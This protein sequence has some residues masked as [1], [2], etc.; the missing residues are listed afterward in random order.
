MYLALENIRSLYN[1][2]SILRTAEFFGV[3]RVLLVGYSGRKN[4][5]INELHDR[6][7]KTSLG[8]EKDLEI[9]FLDNSRDLIKFSEDRNLSLVGVEIDKKSVNLSSFKSDQNSVLVFGNEIKGVSKLVLKKAK[10]IIE[11]LRK[12]K[13]GSLNVALAAGVVI[14]EATK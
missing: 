6:V 1:V 13:K 3:K 8:A 14:Y 9:T 2:G 12:G 5:E 4:P 10:K 7:K 11:I